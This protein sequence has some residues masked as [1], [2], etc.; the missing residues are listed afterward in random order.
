MKALLFLATF[1]AATYSFAQHYSKVKIFTDADGLQEL[2]SLGVAVD[3]GIQKKGVFFISDFSSTEIQILKEHNFQYEILVEDMEEYAARNSQAKNLAKNTNCNDQQVLPTPPIHHFENSTYAGFYR[4][5][6]MLDALDSMATLYP[7]LITV[8]APISTFLTHENRPI[9]HVKISDSPNTDDTT[10]PNVLYTSV[11]HAREPMSMSQT[12]FYMWYLLENYATD[13]EIQF[14]V[15][16][17]E[18]YFIPCLNPD[19]YIFNEANNPNGFGMH[20]KNKAP[21]GTSNPGVD[22]NRNYSYLWNT[23][24]VSGDVDSDVYPG[25]SAF[26]EPETQ[27]LKWLVE[28]VGFKSAFNTHSYGEILLHPIGGDVNE[29]ADHH[30]YFTDLSAEMCS[31]NGYNPQKATN[32]Y[33]ASGN[34]DDYFYKMDIGLMMK[35]TIFAMTPETGSEFWP[36]QFEVVPT[37][38]AMI[39][40]NMLLSHI[41]HRY[42]IL[43]DLDPT[44]LPSITGN[45]NHSV[46]RLGLESGAVDVYVTP[47]QNILSVGPTASYDLGFHGFTT[48]SISYTLDPAIQFGDAIVYDLVTDYGPW[49]HHDTITKLYGALG[50]VVLDNA[51]NAANWNGTWSSTTDDSYSPN[52]SFTDSDGSDYSNFASETFEYN[53][54]IDLTTAEAAK[55]SFYAKWDIELDYDYCQFQVRAPGGGWEGQCGLHTSAGFNSSWS[56]GAQPTDE[57]IWEG[58]SDWVYEE[59]DLSDYLGETINVRFVFG[60]DDAVT[61]DGFYFDDFQVTTRNPLSVNETQLEVF[62]VPNPANHEFTIN[63]SQVLSEGTIVVY[64]QSGKLVLEKAMQAHSNETILS[65]AK[66][67]NGAYLVHVVNEKFVANPIKLIVLH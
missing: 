7:N 13:P 15:D 5:Q 54:Q 38:Q 33:A 66:L 36:P 6:D 61:M 34:S 40:P 65:T 48:G 32:L 35:D 9:Y 20:R 25:T 16:N 42:I 62:A 30:D 8:K 51:N 4:Y 49:Q 60:S 64:D 22:L 17:T 1:F 63:T 59:I 46:E 67:P 26:S 29:F 39:Y 47:I 45:F 31:M 55:I 23:A 2:A 52:Y 24:G 27:A 56:S 10:E 50:T 53:N 43:E 37:C 44:Y 57:P 11:H 14:L 58:T 12:I 41:A 18:M 3:H 19:G 28:Q 21:V